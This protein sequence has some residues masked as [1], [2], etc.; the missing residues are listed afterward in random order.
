MTRAALAPLDDA[1]THAAVL[2]SQDFSGISPGNKSTSPNLAALAIIQ[3]SLA[4]DASQLL[5]PRITARLQVPRRADDYPAALKN[6]GDPKAAKA[7]LQTLHAR[8]DA[9]ERANLNRGD[10]DQDVKR[11]VAADNDELDRIEQADLV[12]PPT[13]VIGEQATPRPTPQP[14]PR[15]TPRPTPTRR[16]RS[17][18]SRRPPGE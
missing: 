6:P 5:A 15:P 2:A 8:L 14:T 18:C 10:D 7:A 4:Q 16:T 11:L 17:V 1:A 9:V 12:A 13:L 3:T